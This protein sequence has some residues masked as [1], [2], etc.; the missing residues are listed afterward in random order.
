MSERKVEIGDLVRPIVDHG[1]FTS[2]SSR[3]GYAIVI[4]IDPFIMVSENAD[5]RWSR[6]SIENV[7]PFAKASDEVLKVCMRRKDK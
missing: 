4:S 3:Y 6:Y 2:G 7:I 1:D 5:M